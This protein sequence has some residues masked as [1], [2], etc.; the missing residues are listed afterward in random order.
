VQSVL[1][2]YNLSKFFN[3][4]YLSDDTISLLPGYKKRAITLEFNLNDL[5]LDS[6]YPSFIYNN[7]QLT[8]ED[9]DNILDSNY[10]SYCQNTINTI[11][12]LEKCYN[13]FKIRNRIDVNNSSIS[14]KIIEEFMIH[15]NKSIASIMKNSLYRHHALPYANKAGYL[16]RFIGYQ[17][18]INVPL[19]IDCIKEFT[20]IIPQENTL[21]YLTKHMMSKALYTTEICFIERFLD[22]LV[23][24]YSYVV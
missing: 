9:F 15:A 5:S 12:K 19:E 6:W 16:Q 4:I 24:K 18:N 2:R 8:Y 20:K 13:K 21:H 11:L 10:N 23:Y 7:Y 17:L 3:T 14:H 1:L 22:K